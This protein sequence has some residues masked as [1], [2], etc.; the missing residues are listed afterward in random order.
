MLWWRPKAVALPQRFIC[1]D[2]VS[3]REM[4][5]F[6]NHIFGLEKAYVFA[7]LALPFRCPCTILLA[8]LT[9]FWK[10]LLIHGKFCEG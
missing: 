2:G 10:R 7:D 4:P 3:R 6:F 1:C 5:S 9:V 8:L